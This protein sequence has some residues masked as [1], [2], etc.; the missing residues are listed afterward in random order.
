MPRHGRDAPERIE[1]QPDVRQEVYV[2]LFIPVWLQGY[3]STGRTS[4]ADLIG[5][6]VERAFEIA[7]Q[8]P[9]LVV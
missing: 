7:I 8:V 9:I 4:S 6:S 2:A 5:S 3:F 1:L